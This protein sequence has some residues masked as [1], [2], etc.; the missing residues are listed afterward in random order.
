MGGR[1]EFF[2]PVV[3]ERTEPV[4]H[5]RW[6]RRIFGIV[7]CLQPLLGRNIDAFRDATERLPTET[8]LSS[9][10][11]RWLAGAQ[12]RLVDTGY[13]DAGEVDAAL[14][15]RREH[16]GRRRVSRARLTAT[17]WA[18]RSVARPVLPAWFAG[19]VLPAV[20]GGARPAL[21]R[22][23]FGIGDRI[24][25]RDQQASGHTRQPGYVSGKPGVV[26]AHLGATVFPDAHAVGRRA[27]PQHLYTVAFDAADLWGKNAEPGTEVRVDLYESYLE[28]A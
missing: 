16:P 2:G 3:R 15:G 9:Y 13:L 4:F 19:R 14:A 17:G 6:E 23:R 18:L 26:V 22:R 12:T 25:V 10:Y 24:R 7:F 21:R 8:Y 20:L 28:A 5:E 1:T 11:G 27:W